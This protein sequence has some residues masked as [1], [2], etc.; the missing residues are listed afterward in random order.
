MIESDLAKSDG[1]RSSPLRY[2]RSHAVACPHISLVSLL[3]EKREPKDVEAMPGEG[4][5]GMILFIY[6]IISYRIQNL[7]SI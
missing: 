4:K 2:N 7:F 5:R 3:G 6:S 1:D